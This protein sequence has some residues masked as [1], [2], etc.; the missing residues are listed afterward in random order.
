M[1]YAF[2]LYG[3]TTCTENERFFFLTN[4]MKLFHEFIALLSCHFV[5][6]C[7]IIASSSL[8]CGEMKE[9]HV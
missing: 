3:C 4:F 6:L 7:S 2:H 8:C 5:L 9:F 1:F